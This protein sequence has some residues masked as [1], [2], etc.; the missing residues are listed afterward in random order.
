MNRIRIN[1]SIQNNVTYIVLLFLGIFV[2][3]IIGEEVP[4]I[5]RDTGAYTTISQSDA[6]MPIYPMFA[7]VCRTLFG[8]Y[9]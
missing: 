3:F 8:E 6:V 4:M 7:Y 1:T 2:F 9:A 5:A